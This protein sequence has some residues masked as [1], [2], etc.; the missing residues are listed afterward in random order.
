MKRKKI[1]FLYTE[2]AS[3]FLAC[4]NQLLTQQ[5]FEVHIVR[6]EINKEAPFKFDF[7]NDLFVYERNAYTDHKLLELI[8]T[9]SPSILVCSGWIDKGYLKICKA[10]KNKAVTV[11]TLDNNWRGTLK[12]NL[13]CLLSPFYLHSRFSHCWVPGAP[14]LK[15]ALKLGFREEVVLTGFYSA[16]VDFFH[17]QCLGTKEEKQANFPKKFIYVGRYVSHKGIADLWQ[18]FIDLQ[19]EQPNVWE[20]WCL[21]T[22]DIKPVNHPKIKH[23]GFVQPGDLAPFI[24]DAGVFVLPSHNE[25][26]GVVVHEFAAAGFPIICSDKVGARTAFVENNLNGYIYPSGNV[27]AL[28]ERMRTM[29]NLNEEALNDMAQ[30]SVKKAMMIT[31]DKWAKQLISLI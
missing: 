4:V 20:L 29:I 8:N 1:V 18:A 10:Y 26:W 15:Y 6:Y 13:L 23:M 7:S 14:Q 19:Q 21:G 31:P 30:E 3:Y 27:K 5:A 24:S 17:S 11:L 28:K 12:Q 16:D 22:G 2:I 9:I 25:P